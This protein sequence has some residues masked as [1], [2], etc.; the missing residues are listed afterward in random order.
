MRRTPS[1]LPE[2]PIS[3]LDSLRCPLVWT[4]SGLA[5][6]VWRSLSVLQNGYDGLRSFW[7]DATKALLEVLEEGY[8]PHGDALRRSSG[9][10]VRPIA[11][12]IKSFTTV[13]QSMSS[14]SAPS[15]VLMGG[16]RPLSAPRPSTSK[17]RR[18]SML[19]QSSLLG[20]PMRTPG[21]K[22]ASRSL[23]VGQA[24]KT[25]DQ[26]FAS[27]LGYPFTPLLGTRPAAIEGDVDTE[28][29]SLAT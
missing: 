26:S 7:N 20:T 16:G 6:D 10:T 2:L 5:F 22:N 8:S 25:E 19:R 14:E 17:K 12:R 1:D 9:G 21:K 18:T 29:E 24:G 4:G 11:D 13:R 23:A 27:K 28:I 15:F 3:S